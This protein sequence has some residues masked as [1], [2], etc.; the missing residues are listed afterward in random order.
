[1]LM[2][3]LAVYEWP[4]RADAAKAR[5]LSGCVEW[6]AGIFKRLEA[7]AETARGMGMVQCTRWPRRI[8]AIVRREIGQVD[9]EEDSKS[10]VEGQ[11]GPEDEGPEGAFGLGVS[12]LKLGLPIS[13]SVEGD[14]ES[15]EEAVH[16]QMVWDED[17]GLARFWDEEQ[18]VGV[19]GMGGAAH[20][21]GLVDPVLVTTMGSMDQGMLTAA[22]SEGASLPVIQG[23][24]D[25]DMEML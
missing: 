24:V 7:T 6:A 18:A 17:G 13:P 3:P 5:V 14:A 10:W 8:M 12:V 1:M 15:Q 25:L 20:G 21:D 4:D 11:Q 16:S 19:V 23:P 22:V 2:V 9:M